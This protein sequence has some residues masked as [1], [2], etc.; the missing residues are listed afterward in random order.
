MYVEHERIIIE[1]AVI[2]LCLVVFFRTAGSVLGT[3]MQAFLSDWDKI[4]AVVSALHM[5]VIIT[6]TGQ[7]AEH[8]TSHLQTAHAHMCVYVL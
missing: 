4:T 7:R 5:T 2:L 8:I 3:G 1:G 6:Y